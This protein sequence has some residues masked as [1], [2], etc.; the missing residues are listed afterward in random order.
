MESRPGTETPGPPVKIEPRRVVHQ[1]GILGVLALGGLGLRDGSPLPGLL[2]HGSLATGLAAGAAAGAGI[3]LLLWAFG[4]IP[5]VRALE[6]WQRAM[7]A[8]WSLADVVGIALLSGLTEEA[9]V[10]ALFQPLVGL[11]PAALIFGLLHIVPD[12][13]TWVWPLLA[14]VLGLALGVLFARWG[15]PA[16]ACAHAA[17][18]LGGFLRLKLTRPAAPGP[19][20]G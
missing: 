2:P 11:V 18:N 15:Y 12:R 9:L 6:R 8:G 4:R 7:V 1:E 19:G 16:A 20:S 10:R 17:I 14:V 3:V 5:A 13:E